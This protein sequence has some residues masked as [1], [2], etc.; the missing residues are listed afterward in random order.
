MEV[1][2]NLKTRLNVILGVRVENLGEFS[3]TK[4]FLLR[5]IYKLCMGN[6]REN[7]PFEIFPSRN[8]PYLMM[9]NCKI[10][11]RAAKPAQKFSHTI[12]IIIIH[13]IDYFHGL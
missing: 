11:Q 6:S 5:P 9:E 3:S 2:C 8:W 10:M 7:F 12:Q 4:K 13:F 1:A